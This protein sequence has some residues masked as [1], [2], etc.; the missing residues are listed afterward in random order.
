MFSGCSNLNSITCLA[1]N[2]ITNQG[3][4]DSWLYGVASTGTF[5]QALGATWPNGKDGIPSGWTVIVYDANQ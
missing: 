4:C 1:E 2:G 3:N 5:T